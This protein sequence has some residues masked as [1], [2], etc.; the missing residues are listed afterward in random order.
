MAHMY[1]HC[2][3]HEGLSGD[4]RSELTLKSGHTCWFFPFACVS[5]GFH[6]GHEYAEENLLFAA[7]VEPRNAAREDKYQWV[8]QQRGQELCTVRM[9][10]CPLLCSS[11]N[12]SKASSIGEGRLITCLQFA[13]CPW[14]RRSL[15]SCSILLQA[16]GV[17]PHHLYVAQQGEG[18]KF[19]CFDRDFLSFFPLL[20][21]FHQSGFCTVAPPVTRKTTHIILFVHMLL[22]LKK[23]LVCMTFLRE[24]DTLSRLEYLVVVLIQAIFNAFV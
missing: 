3:H 8:L 22:L 19:S 14:L 24:I 6:S 10:L 15:T 11:C 21:S 16:L 12:S 1:S 13:C 17:E 23:C 7:E 2:C 9:M 5:T 4:V 18:P 20:L